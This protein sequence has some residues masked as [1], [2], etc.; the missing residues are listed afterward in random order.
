MINFLL[1][2]VSFVQLNLSFETC[3]FVINVATLDIIELNPAIGT[4]IISPTPVV[5]RVIPSTNPLT[6]V[7]F[8][9]VV[10]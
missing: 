7:G 2:P 4:P 10:I 3:S 6:T 5:D 9:K 1:Q 8:Y